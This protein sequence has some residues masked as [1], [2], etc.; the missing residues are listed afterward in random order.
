MLN[1]EQQKRE[2]GLA[3]TLIDD[4]IR[5]LAANDQ[6][7]VVHALATFAYTKLRQVAESN[8]MSPTE[9]TTT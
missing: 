9:R 2:L 1:A 3:K 6:P 5:W 8:D 4:A 7:Q